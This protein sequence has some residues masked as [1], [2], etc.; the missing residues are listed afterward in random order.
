M[1]TSSEKILGF[2]RR[3]S[4]WKNHGVKDLEI[5]P[6]LLGLESEEGY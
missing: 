6:L 1:L 2:K 4:L 3:L 5:F